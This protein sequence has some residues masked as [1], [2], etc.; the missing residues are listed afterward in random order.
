MP[1]AAPSWSKPTCRRSWARLCSGP[2]LRRSARQSGALR[3]SD[4]PPL[5]SPE[6]PGLRAGLVSFRR[7]IMSIPEYA[8]ANFNTTL[9]AAACGD[10]ALVECADAMTGEP[11]YVICAVAR[12][13]DYVI[14]PFG[15]L[16]PGNPYEAYEPPLT[17]PEPG[18][19]APARE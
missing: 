4:D 7:P 1:P 10:L 9:R 5:P 14:T 2:R 15:H 18:E 8:R 12:G 11:R 3:P 13:A 17:S 16:A 6:E 19:P